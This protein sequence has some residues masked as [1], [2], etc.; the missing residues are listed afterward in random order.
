ML[1]VV[2][3]LIPWTVLT[4]LLLQSYLKDR[5]VEKKHLLWAMSGMTLGFFM[6]LISPFILDLFDIPSV[7]ILKF[8]DIFHLFALYSIYLLLTDFE[9]SKRL[10]VQVMSSLFIIAGLIILFDPTSHQITGGF[11]TAAYDRGVFSSG[12]MLAA[13]LMWG[14]VAIVFKRF[15]EQ[16]HREHLRKS[17]RYF[18]LACWFA[19]L[20]YASAVI[21]Y[22]ILKISVGM[23]LARTL[24]IVAGFFM[25]LGA[26]TP[27]LLSDLHLIAEQHH[28]LGEEKKRLQH[29]SVGT[30]I[31]GEIGDPEV[32]LAAVIENAK[33]HTGA[34]AVA[35]TKWYH[36][37]HFAR[38]EYAAIEKKK[39]FSDVL[40]NFGFDL[41]NL[42]LPANKSQVYKEMVLKK[43]SVEMDSL[44][45]VLNRQIPRHRCEKIQQQFLLNKF[46][47]HPLFLKG[48]YQGILSFAFRDEN[49]DR[50][51]VSVYANECEQLLQL[52][53]ILEEVRQH[54]QDLETTNQ[55]MQEL[56]QARLNHAFSLKDTLDTICAAI[57]SRLE[58]ALA[59]IWQLQNNHYKMISC[60]HSKEVSVNS[61]ITYPH[62]NGFPED[63][64]VKDFGFTTAFVYP[65]S[66]SRGNQLGC[67]LVA[68]NTFHTINDRE[69]EMLKFFSGW[70]AVEIERE[71]QTQKIVKSEEKYRSLFE[72]AL[73]GIYQI[74]PDGTLITAN[75]ALVKMLGYDSE[76]ELFQTTFFGDN[77]EAINFLRDLKELGQIAGRTIH[78]QRKDGD[79][80]IVMAS[81]QEIK[82]EHGSPLYYEGVFQDITKR[83]I[84]E[85]QLLRAQKMESI[86]TLASG[87]AHD[88]N[89]SLSAILPMAELVKLK[90]DD[91]KV[92]QKCIDVIIDAAKHSSKLAGQLLTLSKDRQLVKTSVN[93]NDC[94]A[95]VVALLEKTLPKDY[96]LDVHLDPEISFI[97]A[98]PTQIEQMLINLVINARDSFV[99][100][101]TKNSAGKII[102]ISTSR[103][104]PPSHV[105]ASDKKTCKPNTNWICLSIADTGSGMDGKTVE[106]IFEPFF[107]TKNFEQGTGLGLAMVYAIAQNHGGLIDVTSQIGRGTTFDIYFTVQAMDKKAGREIAPGIK[108]GGGHLLVVDDQEKV[109][110]SLSQ[111]LEN[112][113]YDCTT[114][115]NGEIA[116]EL[117]DPAVHDAVI[118]DVSMPGLDGVTTFERLQKRFADVKVLL[119]SGFA[120]GNSIEKALANGAYGFIRKPFDLSQISSEVY[121]LMH[122]NKRDA[123]LW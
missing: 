101:S 41:K 37:K 11:L 69:N 44:Y 64:F 92:V 114:V 61:E 58:C 82:N 9:K 118:L 53:K 98:E 46:V 81:A 77:P 29:L 21:L 76:T 17:T 107:S 89:N 57:F 79:E 115:K 43:K 94:V 74:S 71:N 33:V 111:I 6:S 55:L 83:K 67:L 31:L 19:V 14:Y 27:N 100:Q 102:T 121:R 36:L 87:V 16:K 119:I 117:F 106:R 10:L 120:R 45:D 70:I 13:M 113:G 42:K 40:R 66:D 105:L 8:F 54:S 60:K 85:R 24:P 122:H 116:I 23:I 62:K 7:T 34:E 18:S 12:V 15:G 95:S 109:R 26:R 56:Q 59:G 32:L 25:Y 123:V 96:I 30:S 38:I 20:S 5:T 88:F 73:E 39:E 80:L 104:L 35:L 63:L 75:P 97:S 52:M 65:M 110:E 51:L 86:G 68:R 1:F 4:F 48:N 2:V 103:S 72:N 99:D 93:L 84:L 108:Q 47:H 112:L 78:L 3:Q 91:T 28:H 49:F 90:A 22:V 50:N